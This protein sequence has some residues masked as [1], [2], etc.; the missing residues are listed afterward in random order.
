MSVLVVKVDVAVTG[1]S[2]F[3][4]VPYGILPPSAGFDDSIHVVMVDSMVVELH[5]T[6][7]IKSSASTNGSK[8]DRCDFPI[9]QQSYLRSSVLFRTDIHSL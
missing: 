9:Q 6:P 2:S 8:K 5:S 3:V 1:G 4:Q 7:R